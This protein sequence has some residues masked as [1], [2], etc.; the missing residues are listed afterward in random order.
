MERLW[1]ELG[2]FVNCSETQELSLWL[3]V[4]LPSQSSTDGWGLHFPTP[5]GRPLIDRTHS[6]PQ[7]GFKL[8]TLMG[9][10]QMGKWCGEVWFP[11]DCSHQCLCLP[12]PWLLIVFS[13]PR[14]LGLKA[15]E[16]VPASTPANICCLC[17]NR[18]SLSKDQNSPRVWGGERRP[19]SMFLSSYFPLF[20][21]REWRRRNI[22]KNKPISK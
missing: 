14:L 21:P 12:S 9:K 10:S 5:W 15:L 2:Q 3:G 7:R 19:S 18:T 20:P 16:P 4:C 13:G 22:V 17:C 6:L 11:L 1:W 8:S